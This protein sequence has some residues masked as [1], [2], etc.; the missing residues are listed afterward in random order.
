MEPTESSRH[1]TVKLAARPAGHQRVGDQAGVVARRTG[2][3]R[4][5]FRRE[6]WR[7][8]SVH[9]VVA[10]RGVVRVAGCV[11]SVGAR[12][13]ERKPLASLGLGLTAALRVRTV[14]VVAP[15]AA[16]SATRTA[17]RGRRRTS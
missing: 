17:P 12:G 14:R 13:T 1:F 6:R 5:G 10:S 15:G 3:R 8:G 7:G 4:A 11:C 9:V 16:W 2:G